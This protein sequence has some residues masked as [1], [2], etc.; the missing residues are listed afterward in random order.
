MVMSGTGATQSFG[1]QGYTIAN[2]DKGP[3]LCYKIPTGKMK[4]FAEVQAGYVKNNPGPGHYKK[5]LPWLKDGPNNVKPTEKN[6]F[7]A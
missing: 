4:G 2:V 5:D 3:G 7:I 6:S 1:I